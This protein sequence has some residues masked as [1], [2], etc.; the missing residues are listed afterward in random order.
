MELVTPTAPL[1]QIA[2]GEAP[3]GQTLLGF[4]HRDEIKHRCSLS[5]WLITG[6]LRD[7]CFKS[8]KLFFV[9]V[10]PLPLKALTLIPL[11]PHACQLFGQLILLPPPALQL[12]LLPDNARQHFCHPLLHTSPKPHTSHSR[13]H[14]APQKECG[15]QG[16]KKMGNPKVK[17]GRSRTAGRAPLR[18][19]AGRPGGGTPL[20]AEKF[21]A[22]ETA[23]ERWPGKGYKRR[24]KRRGERKL[25]IFMY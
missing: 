20:R 17:G 24:F 6:L 11:P 1:Q 7:P 13:Q 10:G 22:T 18:A 9:Q 25:Q 15:S 4:R 3:C 5:V 8:S 16:G 14:A 23:E 12:R 19:A 21:S 2:H